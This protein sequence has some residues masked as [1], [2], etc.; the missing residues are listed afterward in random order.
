MDSYTYV[1]DDKAQDYHDMLN[2]IFYEMKQCRDNGGIAMT[3]DID[4]NKHAIYNW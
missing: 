4:G 1:R 2:K 3:L